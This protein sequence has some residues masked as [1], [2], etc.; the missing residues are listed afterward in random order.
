[1]CLT[2]AQFIPGRLAAWLVLA[3][4]TAASLALAVHRH[5]RQT[6][7]R[8]P[9]L[10]RRLIAECLAVVLLVTAAFDIPMTRSHT[11]GPVVYHVADA[12]FYVPVASGLVDNTLDDTS[13]VPRWN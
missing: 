13:W 8:L 7:R 10:E 6:G 5:H 12:D 11:L 4:L 1:V 2:T 3:P 9:L